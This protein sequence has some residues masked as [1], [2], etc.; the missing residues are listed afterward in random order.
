MPAKWWQTPDEWRTNHSQLILYSFWVMW[1]WMCVEYKLLRI[2]NRSLL[3]KQ[4]CCAHWLNL[5]ECLWNRYKSKANQYGVYVVYW[6]I[7]LI[8]CSIPLWI[9]PYLLVGRSVCTRSISLSL[10][11]SVFINGRI[12]LRVFSTKINHI[13]LLRNFKKAN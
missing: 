3:C 8:I 13:S 7:S 1:K 6:S 12:A 11:V 4:F 9:N 5:F 2:S 10:C